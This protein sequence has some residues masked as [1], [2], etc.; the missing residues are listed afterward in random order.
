MNGEEGQA[1]LKKASEMV[2]KLSEVSYR[3][4]KG[5]GTRRASLG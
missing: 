4:R 1:G 5:Q 3:R 2:D